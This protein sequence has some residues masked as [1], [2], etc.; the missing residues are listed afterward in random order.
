MCDAWQDDAEAMA[1]SFRDLAVLVD[2]GPPTRQ[3]LDRLSHNYRTLSAVFGSLVEAIEGAGS[4]SAMGADQVIEDAVSSYRRASSALDEVADIVEATDA[5][6]PDVLRAM[7]DEF[8]DLERRR[9]RTPMARPSGQRPD[10]I[11]LCQR[12][13]VSAHR[14]RARRCRPGVPVKK[15]MGLV[16]TRLDSWFEGQIDVLDGEAGELD[17]YSVVRPQRRTPAST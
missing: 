3:A 8:Q 15:V 11:R 9:R 10:L 16:A 1:D 5:E 12:R 6:D 17:D 14:C 4:P 13:D 7:V 2:T